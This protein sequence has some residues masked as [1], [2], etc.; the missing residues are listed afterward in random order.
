MIHGG[1]VEVIVSFF[2]DSPT[3]QIAKY[4]NFYFGQYF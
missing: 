3:G 2:I 4:V 1:E